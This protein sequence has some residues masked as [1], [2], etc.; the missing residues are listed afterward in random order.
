MLLYSVLVRDDR[1]SL[2]IGGWLDEFRTV[3]FRA[4]TKFVARSLHTTAELARRDV[5]VAGRCS[6]NPV[7]PY[8]LANSGSVCMAAIHCLLQKGRCKW[9]V[10]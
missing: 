6:V 1:K 3:R 7:M 2:G 8:K 10:L 4:R 5:S 9:L